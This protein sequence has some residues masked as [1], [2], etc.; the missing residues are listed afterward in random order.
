MLETLKKFAAERLL[1]RGESDQFRSRHAD[2]ALALAERAEPHLEGRAEQIEWLDELE[3]ERDNFR[4]AATTLGELNRSGEAL[5]LPTALW[6]LWLMRGPISEGRLLV[7]AALEEAGADDSV[8]RAKALR[9][10]GNFSYASGDWRGAAELHEQALEL[11][12]RVGDEGEEALALLAVAADAFADGELELARSRAEAGVRLA[13]DAGHLR[14][15]AAGESMLGVLALHE[16][17]YIR[18]RALFE[19][20]IAAMGGEEFGTVVNLGNLALAAFR[21][22]DLEEAAAKLRENLTLSL[23]LHDHLS[24]THA[25]EVLAAVLAARG[26]VKFAARVLGASAGLR[27]EEDLSLQELESELHEETVGLVRE[28]LE[29]GEFESQLAAGRDVGLGE[30]IRSAIA[31]LD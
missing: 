7:E 22:G 4:I 12:R 16:R 31:R 10:L 28:Q 29:T 25:L 11:S 23:R 3:R 17:D 20:S 13:K 5:R 1:Q 15:A 8:D 21:L 9:V 19:E 24:T 30:L 14:S 6:R 26:D 2:W 27:E 18:A